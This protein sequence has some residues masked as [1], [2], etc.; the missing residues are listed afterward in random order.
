MDSPDSGY[1]VLVQVEMVELPELPECHLG[2]L[3]QV[4]VGEDQVLEAA[5]Q[6]GDA[7]RHEGSNSCG[8]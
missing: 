3:E 6:G 4:V 5:G 8:N 2:H 7:V 1:V